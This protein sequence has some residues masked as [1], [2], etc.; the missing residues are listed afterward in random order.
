MKKIL[1]LIPEKVPQKLIMRGF[2]RGFKAN[3]YYVETQFEEELT[4]EFLEKTK[5]E[6]ILSYAD[7]SSKSDVLKKY[8]KT[9]KNVKNLV[10]FAQKKGA[11]A[12]FPPKTLVFAS[13]RYINQ[14]FN[15]LPLAISSK[16]YGRVFG[17]YEWCIT[18]V[19]NPNSL[20]RA[21][22]L[23]E[24]VRNFGENLAIFC[25]KKD[26]LASVK[27][28]EKFLSPDELVTYKYSYQRFLEDERDISQVLN[29]SKINLNI[30]KDFELSLNF[31][32][33]EV[34]AAGGFL[35]TNNA[36][37]ANE[38]FDLGRDLETYENKY[39]LVDKIKFYLKQPDLAQIIAMNGQAAIV[40]GHT[41]KDRVKVILKNI[42]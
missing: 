4:I 20:Y 38:F 33:F 9:N 8:L 40:Q 36:W 30:I 19:G 29:A 41:F 14:K 6:L 34:L 16:T 21:E 32:A 39:D 1:I 5:A 7:F 35:I 2:C 28:I 26:F 37:A 18:F 15:Y 24:V 12:K 22:I 25:K 27:K 13:D 42:K 11:D 3:K 31:H 17:K 10:Y 23:A